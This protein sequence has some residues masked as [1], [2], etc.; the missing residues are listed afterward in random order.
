MKMQG[1]ARIAFVLITMLYVGGVVQHAAKTTLASSDEAGSILASKEILLHGL[2]L[3]PSQQIYYR[4][5]LPHYLGAL[6]IALIGD[7]TLG[8]RGASLLAYALLLVIPALM[9][10]RRGPPLLGPCWAALAGSPPPMLNIAISGRMYM[11]YTFFA[12][13][14]VLLAVLWQP[15]RWNW[16]GWVYFL[17]CTA[18]AC[19]HEHFVVF[20]PGLILCALPVWI[21]NRKEMSLARF[22]LNP[23][24]TS[25]IFAFALAIFWHFSEPLIPNAFQNYTSGLRLMGGSPSWV[26]PLNVLSQ[27]PMSTLLI[28]ILFLVCAW[29]SKLKLESSSAVGFLS[30][31]ASS[32]VAVSLMLPAEYSYYVMP[33]W[34]VFLLAI[35]G[36]LIREQ[37]KPRL[38]DGRSAF[39]AIGALATLLFF[40][41]GTEASPYQ[42]IG[43]LYTSYNFLFRAPLSH[44]H[45]WS[46]LQQFAQTTNPTVITS[47][48]ELLLLHHLEPVAAHVR[49]F[50]VPAATPC[51]VVMDDYI[52][53]PFVHH[54]CQLEGI[55]ADARLKNSPVLFVGSRL[56][57]TIGPENT[58]NIRTLFTKIG[59]VDNLEVYC[60]GAACRT[61]TLVD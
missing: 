41:I 26:Y 1:I 27:S 4:S 6:S 45:R 39:V 3:V 58:Q 5:L 15:L 43:N 29:H 56:G 60:A 28:L 36:V 7:N 54:T 47:E 17:V 44:A 40:A 12:T 31:L 42:R 46:Q 33:L 13:I 23:S 16:R 19:S 59:T 14:A 55:L 11:I 51:S 10:M 48:P 32:Y 24:V 35:F 57:D 25:P 50:N 20:V 8:W 53:V 37:G 22:C 61:L 49:A 38:P 2:P 18:A 9:L 21:K 34:P 52:T 30:I